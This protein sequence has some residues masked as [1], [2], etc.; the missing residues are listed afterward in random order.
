MGLS[1]LLQVIGFLP[2][3]GA[4]GKGIDPLRTVKV[5]TRFR[6]TNLTKEIL[7]MYIL[8]CVFNVCF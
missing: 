8:Y 1:F 2:H 4:K 7:L 3:G 6:V 5:A